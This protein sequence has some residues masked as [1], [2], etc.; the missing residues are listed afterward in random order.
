MNTADSTYLTNAIQQIK[1]QG[2][3]FLPGLTDDEVSAAESRWG[4]KFPQDLRA[5]L[6][7]AMPAPLEAEDYR[8]KKFPNWTSTD[9]ADIDYIKY[10]LKW[11]LGMLIEDVEIN[12]FWMTTWGERPSDLEQA[13]QIATQHIKAAPILI[14]ILFHRFMPAEPCE[15]GNPVFSM[16]GQDT[17]CY[18]YDL[19]DYLSNE[20]K[21]DKPQWAARRPRKIDFWSQIAAPTTDYKYRLH[22]DVESNQVLLFAD[23]PLAVDKYGKR[24]IEL[25]E[26][27]ILDKYIQSLRE[28]L[29]KAHE[30]Y[31]PETKL[32][33]WDG[34]F[35]EEFTNTI[36]TVCNQINH[37]ANDEFFVYFD[38][39]ENIMSS[40]LPYL[41]SNLKLF[42]S[43]KF[44]FY[45]GE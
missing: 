13:K 6:Q 32:I 2:I 23:T 21:L 18:G 36:H 26:M 39:S 33:A 38:L 22:L 5:F 16:F 41:S 24:A 4:F 7:I 37:E 27:N 44:H 40:I 12:N 42:K 25:S 20:F 43:Q 28:V 1:A 35:V 10:C 29:N 15:I 45:Q 14:P 9:K 34:K 8:N 30:L 11:P 17:I 31:Q 3:Q 19:A